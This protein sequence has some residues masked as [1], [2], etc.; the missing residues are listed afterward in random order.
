MNW[1]EQECIDLNHRDKY[2]N[3]GNKPKWGFAIISGASKEWLLDSDSLI[4]RH[5]FGCY[6]WECMYYVLVI[7]FLIAIS[8]LFKNLGSELAYAQKTWKKRT[9]CNYPSS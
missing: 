1:F 4:S 5:I 2:L 3:K 9:W 6:S 7:V 8:V